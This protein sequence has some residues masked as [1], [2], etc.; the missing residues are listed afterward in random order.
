MTSEALFSGHLSRRDTCSTNVFLFRQVSS[1][2]NLNHLSTPSFTCEPDKYVSVLKTALVWIISFDIDAFAHLHA[3]TPQQC[4][5]G[6]DG[7]IGTWKFIEGNGR[8]AGPQQTAPRHAVQV[9]K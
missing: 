6:P 7:S 3:G 8:A 4:V 5:P 1:Y 9:A 2:R